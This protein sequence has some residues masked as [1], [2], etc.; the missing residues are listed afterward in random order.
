[1]SEAIAAREGARQRLLEAKI[2]ASPAIP[3]STNVQLR[4]LA[5]LVRGKCSHKAL[6]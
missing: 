5:K 1:M 3:D 2:I 6:R 4:A